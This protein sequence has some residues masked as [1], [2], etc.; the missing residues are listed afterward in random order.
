MKR[1]IALLI[2]AMMIICSTTVLA[3]VNYTHPT[4]GTKTQF[5]TSGTIGSNHSTTEFLTLKDTCST[6]SFSSYPYSISNGNGHEFHYS[7]AYSV[8]DA[9]RISPWVVVYEAE[10]TT[11]MYIYSGWQTQYKVRML[12]SNPYYHDDGYSTY[13]MYT[14]GSYTFTAS[15]IINK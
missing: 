13:T 7:A 8:D 15:A 9:R 14:T 1:A 2:A 12:V 6:V 10:A 4:N 5:L 11:S 3:D